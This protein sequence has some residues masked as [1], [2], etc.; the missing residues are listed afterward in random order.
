MAKI[1]V[2]DDIKN[3]TE[4]LLSTVGILFPTAK[5]GLREATGLIGA[6]IEKIL[7]D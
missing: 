1:L 6:E 4:S 3:E 2:T 7:S 5:G